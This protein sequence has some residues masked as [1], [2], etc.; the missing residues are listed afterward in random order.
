MNGRWLSGIFTNL[1]FLYIALTVSQVLYLGIVSTFTYLGS[2]TFYSISL[3]TLLFIM[4]CALLFRYSRS[5]SFKLL[6]FQNIMLFILFFAVFI[7]RGPL[8]YPAH[9]DLAFHI[10][11]A[12]Y[13]QSPFDYRIFGGIIDHKYPALDLNNTVALYWLG[14]RMTILINGLIFTIWFISL[15]NRFQNSV[16]LYK[17]WTIS[18]VFI[19]I[20]FLP[21]LIAVQGTFMTDGFNILFATEL[22]FQWMNTKKHSSQNTFPFVLLLLFTGFI[23][24]QSNTLFLPLWIY[25]FADTLFAHKRFFSQKLEHIKI[26]SLV[27]MYEIVGLVY[28]IRT[29]IES[30]IYVQSLTHMDKQG[31]G[32]SSVNVFDWIVWPVYGVLT[33][34]YSD[35]GISPVGKALLLFVM[36][37]ITAWLI[38]TICK[39]FLPFVATNSISTIPYGL[40]LSLGASFLMW[41]AL[42]GYGRYIAPVIVI[43]LISMV[44]YLPEDLKP[45]SIAKNSIFTK[46]FALFFI[47]IIVVGTVKS[48]YAWRPYPSLKH[49]EHTA[50]FV[51]QYIQ[52]TKLIFK[53]TIPH[54]QSIYAEQF[55]DVDAVMPVHYGPDTFIAF[56]GGLS[57]KQTLSDLQVA[58]IQ[59][60]EKKGYPNARVKENVEKALNINSMLLVSSG[61]FMSFLPDTYAFNTLNCVNSHKVYNPLLQRTGDTVY[62]TCT[63]KQATSLP[64]EVKTQAYDKRLDPDTFELVNIMDASE[65]IPCQGPV[66]NDEIVGK[67]NTRLIEPGIHNA[68]LPEWCIKP[69]YYV[70]HWTGK[71]NSGD[72]YSMKDFIQNTGLA[73]Q[74]TT[75]PDHIIALMNVYPD[76][77][78]RA[79]CSG[80][81]SNKATLNN[82][83]Q[84]VCFDEVYK[85]KQVPDE[86]PDDVYKKLGENIDTI[87]GYFGSH[88]PDEIKNEFPTIQL[89]DHTSDLKK[90]TE[91]LI[92][93]ACTVRKQYRIPVQ[94]FIGH[95]DITNAYGE[96]PKYDPGQE[97]MKVI[98]QQLVQSCP[99]PEDFP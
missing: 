37:C 75:D 72:V 89:R 33:K 45:I 88:T 51:D 38:L 3:H 53:D 43:S 26:I 17:K 6:S 10:P 23:L 73:C 40:A 56:L 95:Y 35:I 70:V 80:G 71:W 16:S 34:N 83:L 14:I 32:T 61:S 60:Y 66:I 2:N 82:E 92:K 48:D 7:I 63:K 12:F 78:E 44:V 21:T 81:H 25:F 1:P 55:R 62:M 65:I 84:G 28:F 19:I 87:C 98:R 46:I 50:L 18:A 94:H 76:R 42:S 85:G 86:I 9:D 67:D 99:I 79:A 13:G 49:P 36:C 39:K 64:V 91:H 4:I 24:K 97:Y 41:S 15:L 69:S 57:Q 22:L 74:F 59:R 5:F 58:D 77:V 93:H 96:T 20:F 30:H 47:G 8:Y 54:L 27:F 90:M 31:F 11:V 52:G 29:F 68:R